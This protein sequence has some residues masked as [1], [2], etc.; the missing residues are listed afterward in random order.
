IELAKKYDVLPINIAAAYVLCQPSP[1]FAL[2]GPRTLEELRT[3]LPALDVPL[4]P[5]EV[6]WLNLETADVPA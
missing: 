5:E 6:Q 3:S 4:T 2:F 1:I